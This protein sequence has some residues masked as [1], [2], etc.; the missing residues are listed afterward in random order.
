MHEGTD[1][2][3]YVSLWQ[4]H[5]NAPFLTSS[6]YTPAVAPTISSSVAPAPTVAAAAPS[7]SLASSSAPT[8]S[9]AVKDELQE[10]DE[11]YAARHW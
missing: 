1:F 11:L 4:P 2:Q 10:C 5:F 7:L 8:S 9:S 6:S 3:E